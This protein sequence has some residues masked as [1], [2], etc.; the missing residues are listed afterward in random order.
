MSKK[1]YVIFK[2]DVVLVASRATMKARKFNGIAKA[3]NFVANLIRV[4]TKQMLTKADF[5]IEE[6]VE[7]PARKPMVIWYPNQNV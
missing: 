7:A 2:K 6:Y 5:R 3:R 1:T 4:S